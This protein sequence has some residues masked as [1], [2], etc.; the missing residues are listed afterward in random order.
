VSFGSQKAIL[1]IIENLIYDNDNTPSCA[2][3]TVLIWY[4]FIEFYAITATVLGKYGSC[5]NL[6]CC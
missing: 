6:S 5:V 2:P 3:D 4:L 1:N